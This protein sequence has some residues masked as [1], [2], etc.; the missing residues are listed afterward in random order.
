MAAIIKRRLLSLGSPSGVVASFLGRL[1]TTRG[2][3]LRRGASTAERVALGAANSFLGSNGTDALWFT[4]TDTRTALGI[5]VGTFTPTLTFATPGDLSVT[6]ASQTG[7]YV[8]LPTARVLFGIKIAFTA[9][10]T[11]A[12]GAMRVDGLPSIGNGSWVVGQIENDAVIT[13]PA[14]RTAVMGQVISSQTYL[15]FLSVG[16]AVNQSYIQSSN[17]T[18]GVATG[19]SITGAYLS[20]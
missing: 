11:T 6:Y 14:G 8:R 9:T 19:I 16:S 18:S 2:D 10:K 17:V 15:Q 13:Y 20:V 12:S 4:T 7:W 3:L 5:E 1:L